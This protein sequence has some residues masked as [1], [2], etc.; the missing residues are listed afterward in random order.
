MSQIDLVPTLA[1]LLGIPIPY[2]NIGMVIAD[3]FTSLPKLGDD[4]YLEH[5]K[6]LRINAI[7]VQ[8]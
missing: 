1:L 2:S 5:A 8:D 6:A 3:M 7:Q 4:Q